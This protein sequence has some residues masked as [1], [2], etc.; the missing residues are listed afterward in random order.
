[1]GFSVNKPATLLVDNQS[2][3]VNTTLPSSCLKKKHNAIAYHSPKVREA[4][5]AGIVRIAYIRSKE[6]QADILAKPLSPQDYYYL[7]H[8]FLF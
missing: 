4:V 8:G 3:V 6:N 7:L 2:V 5:A 1:M